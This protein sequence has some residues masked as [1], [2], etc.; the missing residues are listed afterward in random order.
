MRVVT[1]LVTAMAISIA[2]LLLLRDKDNKGIT[3]FLVYLLNCIY[4]YYCVG[5]LSMV[6]ADITL[7][8][9]VNRV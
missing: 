3:N 5:T 4:I 6:F 1:Y 7:S 2:C 8:A 9:Y